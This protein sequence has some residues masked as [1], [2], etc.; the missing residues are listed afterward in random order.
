MRASVWLA[1]GLVGLI[2]LV[3]VIAYG[4]IREGVFLA[5]LVMI[6]LAAVYPP[7]VIGLGVVVLAY[8]AIARGGAI[9]FFG[10]I[11]DLGQ[12]QTSVPTTGSELGRGLPNNTG[13]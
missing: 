2:V 11:W 13:A 7:L 5:A 6:L 4:Q 12:T 10:W 9:K 8:V 1:V 3:T